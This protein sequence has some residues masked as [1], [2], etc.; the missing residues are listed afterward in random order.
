MA[1]DPI[2]AVTGGVAAVAGS[3]F[4]DYRNKKAVNRAQD[5]AAGMSNT[6]YQRAVADMKKAG[7]NPMLAYG[8]GGASTPQGE[9]IGTDAPDG[10][11]R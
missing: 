7:L 4:Q 9:M 5:F 3:L 2:S 6:S 1:F 10:T 11:L 8:Q